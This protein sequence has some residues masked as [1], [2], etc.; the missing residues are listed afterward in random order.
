[1]RPLHLIVGLTT[2]FLFIACSGQMASERK[3]LARYAQATITP[4]V[5]L[6]DL[7]L[8]KTTLGWVVKNIGS[9]TPFVQASDE[10]AIELEYLDGELGLLFLVTGECQKETG[11]PQTRLELGRDLNKFL[12]RFPGCGSLTLTSLSVASRQSSA[13]QR[14]YQGQTNQGI[15]L[16]MPI[17]EARKHGPAV[18][19]P[20]QLVP[21][22]EYAE[23]P[24]E[25]VEFL[26]G[27]YVYY[28]TGAGPIAR[29]LQSNQPL[30]P[31]RLR[32]IDASAKEAAKDL[33]IKRIT[34]FQ[35]QE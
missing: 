32:E 21:R 26:G 14:F 15:R 9:G 22:D 35:P 30:S 33:T 1:M 8:G 10:T 6:G 7:Q 31:E 23:E 25:R 28:P 16:G 19:R 17:L 2:V 29:E 24:L 34:I 5:G 13:E 4:G 20:G 3:A 12:A 27:L 11:T 18:Q